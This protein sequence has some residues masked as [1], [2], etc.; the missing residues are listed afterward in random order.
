M[1]GLNWAMLHVPKNRGKECGL[2]RMVINDIV[3]FFKNMMVD[4]L[5]NIYF[6]ILVEKYSWTQLQ[7]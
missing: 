5:A 7:L 2:R 3:L 6:P 4:F 1:D